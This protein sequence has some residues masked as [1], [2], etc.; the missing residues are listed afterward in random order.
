[1]RQR[2]CAFFIGTILVIACGGCA[3][4]VVGAGAGAGGY[5]Y[6]KGEL[7]HTYSM[8][9]K[10]LWPHTL[11]TVNSLDLTVKEKYVDALGGKIEARRNDGTPVKVRLKPAG[12]G[13]TTVGVRVGTFGSRSRSEQVHSAIR[14]HSGV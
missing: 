10:T 8:P 13:S 4:L 7:K 1:M 14:T 5:S 3:A 11:A 6:I 9:V 12:D 2:A